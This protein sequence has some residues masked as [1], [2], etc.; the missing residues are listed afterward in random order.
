MKQK[1][2]IFGW[3]KWCNNF[4][5]AKYHFFRYSFLRKRHR[6]SSSATCFSIMQYVTSTIWRWNIY[7]NYF[8]WTTIVY[9]IHHLLQTYV[10]RNNALYMMEVNRLSPRV[11]ISGYKRALLEC[12]KIVQQMSI[13]ID[14]EN[15]IDKVFIF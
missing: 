2:D 4:R 3:Q 7:A 6:T 1:K 15:Y 8:D 5:S 10:R 11:I 12:K 14:T 13:T 9:L